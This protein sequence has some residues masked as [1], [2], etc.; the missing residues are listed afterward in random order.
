MSKKWNCD[1]NCL[2]V[3]HGFT[4]IIERVYFGEK[5]FA[6][7]SIKP[8]K[9]KEHLTSFHPENATEEA[10][11]FFRAKGAQFEKAGTLSKFGFAI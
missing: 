3:Y 8:A 5:S 7:R 11:F 6:N 2:Y 1:E 10:A 9:L 4:Y